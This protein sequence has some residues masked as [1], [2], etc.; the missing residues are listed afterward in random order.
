MQDDLIDKPLVIV[1]WKDH[2]AEGAWRDVE[3][4]HG[5]AVCHSVGWVWKEDDEGITLVAGYSP[6][7]D[8]STGNLSYILKS[9]ITRRRP[10]KVKP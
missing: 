10:L 7:P 4:F 3:A 2:T 5:P 1:T 8:L 6:S 9:C